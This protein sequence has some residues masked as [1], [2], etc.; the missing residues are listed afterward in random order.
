MAE[1]AWPEGCVFCAIVAGQTPAEVIYEDE[2]TMA[3]MDIHPATWGHAL[4]IPKV[5]FRNLYDIEEGVVLATMRTALKVA[6]AMREALRPDGLDLLQGSEPAGFQT[7]F[8]FHFH[9]V[10]RWWGDGLLRPWRPKPTEIAKIQEAAGLIRER[11][12]VMSEEQDEH[13]HR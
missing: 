11:L 2:A 3:F 9:L 7:I 5:H 4:V 1:R 12:K 8:H 10:P 6:K 13:P